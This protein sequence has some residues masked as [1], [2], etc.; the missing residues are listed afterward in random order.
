M[1]KQR[2]LF[3]LLTILAGGMADGQWLKHRDPE[4]PRMEDGSPNLAAPV[5]KTANGK[6]DL[7]GVW[8]PARDAGGERGGVE[9]EIPPAYFVSLAGGFNPGNLPMLPWAQELF[10]QRMARHQID[11]PTTSCKPAGTAWR[12]AFPAPYKIVQTRELILLLYELDTVY[13]QVFLDGRAL[14]VDP[15]ASYLGYSVGRWEGD[16]L[17]VTT[18]G[19]KDQGWLDAMGHPHTDKLRMEERFRRTDSG[20][21]SLQVTLN[22]PGAYT[23]PLKY[24]QPLVLLPDTD[25]MENFCA[26]NEKDQAH[27]IGN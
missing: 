27:L 18:I 9:N 6:P 10:S 12:P 24:T 17:V 19:L 20:H 8:I 21:M 15:Q 2:Y 5:S 7:S 22:D 14:P 25:V 23:A 11:Q 26:E 3:G 1:K 16:T 4:F 13:R